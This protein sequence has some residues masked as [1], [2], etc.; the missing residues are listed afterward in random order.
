MASKTPLSPPSG[1]PFRQFAYA[2]NADSTQSRYTS[3]E[4]LPSTTA[5]PLQLGRKKSRSSRVT[6]AESPSSNARMRGF[7]L[8]RRATAPAPWVYSPAVQSGYFDTS[9]ATTRLYGFR[10]SPARIRLA[11]ASSA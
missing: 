9:L 6:V 3:T 4:Y 2:K 8:N 1:P 5:A 11:A 7:S 10:L